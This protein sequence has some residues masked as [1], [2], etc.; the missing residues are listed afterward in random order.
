[1]TGRVRMSL[2]L[3][4]KIRERRFIHRQGERRAHGLTRAWQSR[5]QQGT[6]LYKE[7]EEYNSIGANLVCFLGSPKNPTLWLAEV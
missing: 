2:T 1:L 5:A 6:A 3:A 7:R 4:G